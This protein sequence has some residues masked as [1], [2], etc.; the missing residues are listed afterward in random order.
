MPLLRTLI[1]TVLIALGTV[2]L[3][4]WAV[5][6]VAA[7]HGLVARGARRPGLTAAAAGAM[8]W[9]GYLAITALGGGPVTAFGARLAASMQLPASGPFLAT[10]AFPALLAGLAS[11]LGA[12]LGGRYLS[13]P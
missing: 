3:G 7:V 6:A 12:R 5:P 2:L 13:P 9:G 10:L 8:A 1:L 4:W 11:Y